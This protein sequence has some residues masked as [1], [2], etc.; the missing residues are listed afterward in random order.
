MK[1][2]LNKNIYFNTVQISPEF[3]LGEPLFNSKKI[4]E[5]LDELPSTY[6]IVQFPPMSLSG[7][8]CASYF[9]S[10]ELQNNIKLALSNI[11]KQSIKYD[12]IFNCGFPLLS[13][14]G[15]IALEMLIF[16]GNILAINNYKNFR[17][18]K[19]A[20]LRA[21]FEATNLKLSYPAYSSSLVSLLE[22]IFSISD[23]KDYA[24][25][26]DN[27]KIDESQSAL[28][29]H[30]VFSEANDD[31]TCIL[32][33]SDKLFKIK[34]ATDLDEHQSTP[35]NIPCLTIYSLPYESYPSNKNIIEAKLN[36]DIQNGQDISMAMTSARFESSSD[37]SYRGAAFFAC[38]GK[39]RSDNESLG[40]NLSNGINHNIFFSNTF[41]PQIL[42]DNYYKKQVFN[43]S[44]DA[45]SPL[46]SQA[47]SELV[48]SLSAEPVAY[49][50]N[51]L[52]FLPE[53]V[54]TRT[55]FLSEYIENNIS[56]ISRR[57]ESLSFPKIVIGLSGGLDS[58]V[59]LLSSALCL[60]RNNLDFSKLLAVRMPGFGSSAETKDNSANLVMSLGCEDRQISIVDSVNKH[61]HDIG[62]AEGLYDITFENAQARERTQILMD[63][64]NMDSGIVFGTGDLSEIAL[65]WCTYNGD[66]MSMYAING[67]IPKT[68]MPEYLSV[69]LSKI[70]E[71]MNKNSENTLYKIKFEQLVN[72]VNSV[73][74]VPIS[75]ELLPLNEDKNKNQKTENSVGPYLLHDFFIYHKL[76]SGA[77]YDSIY[78]Y[79]C[80]AFDPKNIE[81]YLN[82]NKVDSTSIS[83]STPRSFSPEE[84]ETYLTI[85]KKRFR[86][87]QFKR[88]VAAEAAAATE[89]S[90]SP[91]QAYIYPGDMGA[92]L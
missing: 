69:L 84:I 60:M 16:K 7:I 83:V 63:I 67:S 31:S 71:C 45:P 1:K 17:S 29:N 24:C 62:Q 56:S 9:F 49:H 10:E 2:S 18:T 26:C 91:R 27:K 61:F 66:H 12:F 74:S 53:N 28:N 85:F 36:Y 35:N 38:D 58:T 82:R 39:V 88:S 8:S 64:A 21:F 75:P 48:L 47:S 11:I 3:K 90:L 32:K 65:G 80:E 19:G 4:I 50:F 68:M 57:L 44:Q 87:N 25:I 33:F 79:A 59:A 13:T 54:E 55:Y 15:P 34:L 22:D 72:A 14:V 92:D 89:F 51:P 52:P 86:Q 70:K 6:G 42:H 78:Q 76:S 5:V 81:A 77:S 30:L 46:Y 40:K 20:E 43:Y 41:V 73:I 37:Y 23:F